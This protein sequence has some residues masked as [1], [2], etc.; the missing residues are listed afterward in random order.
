MNILRAAK[1]SRQ[2]QQQQMAIPD[3]SRQWHENV[4]LRVRIGK[5]GTGY[6][7]RWKL[8]FQHLEYEYETRPMGR[9]ACEEIQLLSSQVR[10]TRGEPPK[11]QNPTT[12][13]TASQL[14][15]SHPNNRTENPLHNPPTNTGKGR[16]RDNLFKEK[17]N[18]YPVRERCAPPQDSQHQ[19]AAASVGNPTIRTTTHNTTKQST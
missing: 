4:Q 3:A 17:K 19:S 9:T 18:R 13:G 11:P 2:Q 5:Q 1:A 8:H 12:R 16:Y 6:G 10:S 7:S 15:Q 14:S